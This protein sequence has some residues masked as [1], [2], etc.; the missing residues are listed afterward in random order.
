MVMLWSAIVLLDDVGVLELVE[1]LRLIQQ[2]VHLIIPIHTQA[3][4][5]VRQRPQA[6]LAPA[7][8]LCP[9]LLL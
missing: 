3:H 9:V 8:A 7:P 5:G 2:V 1:D 4:R 6:R